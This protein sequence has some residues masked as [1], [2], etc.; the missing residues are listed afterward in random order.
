VELL[1]LLRDGD[2]GA[3]LGAECLRGEDEGC[4]ERAMRVHESAGEGRR[5]SRKTV[6]ENVTAAWRRALAR[7]T[8]WNCALAVSGRTVFGAATLAASWLPAR[9][10]MRLDPIAVIRARLAGDPS[11]EPT[12]ALR[13]E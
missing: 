9:R 4:G 3:G 2:A 11:Q 8:M 5:G 7:L 6:L 13:S 12:A 1:E 10:A